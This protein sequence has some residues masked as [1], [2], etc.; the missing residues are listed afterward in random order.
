M[1][2]K[3]GINAAG[4][5]IGHDLELI[6]DGEMQQ[7]YN[8]NSSFSYDFGNY[9]R[10]TVGYSIPQLADG[11]HRLLFRAWDV[12]NN[13]SVAELTFVVDSKQQPSI[14]SVACTK[15]PAV[16]STRFLIRHDRA[17]SELDVTLQIFDPSGR[18]LWQRSE[19]ALS[20]GQ[21]YAID[22]DLTLS[23]GFPLSTGVYLYRVLVA[24]NGSTEATAARKLIV[25][26]Q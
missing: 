8:L 1:S 14:L 17:G 2:D 18:M 9:Q 13:S 20:A 10:G 3:D 24:S 23:G 21:T 4:S 19:S 22:W 12:L 5:G 16:N 6:I 7:T 15:N 25:I 26:K 11:P